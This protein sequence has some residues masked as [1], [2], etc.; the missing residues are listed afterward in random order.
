MNAVLEAAQTL[1]RHRQLTWV[2][3]K[4]ELSDR[5]AGQA[6]GLFWVIGHPLLLMGVY[7]FIFGYVFKVRIGGTADLPLDYTTY[8]LSGLVPW[9]ALQESLNKGPVT[10]TGNANLVKQVVFPIEVL[11]VKTILATLAGELVSLATLIIYV[12]ATHHR[13]PWTYVLLPVLLVFQIGITIGICFVLAS[14]GVYF[15]D[16][17]DVV[18]VFTVIGMYLLPVLY[19]PSMVPPLFRPYLYVNPF[20]YLIWCFQDACY[21]GRFEHPWA[22][23]VVTA[24]WLGSLTVGFRIFKRLKPMFGNVL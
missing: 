8:L 2:M 19:L 5:Y 15:R 22:W 7:L 20:S 18:Q 13:L 1:T 23:L 9:L 14:V 16:L 21:F 11:P 24:F 10:I 17:K 4:R 3:A 12:L 6:L